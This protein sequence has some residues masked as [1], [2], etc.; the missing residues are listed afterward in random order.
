MRK[1]FKIFILAMFLMGCAIV[2]K[3]QPTKKGDDIVLSP[4]DESSPAKGQIKTFWKNI[5]KLEEMPKEKYNTMGS[6]VQA[7]QTAINNIKMKDKNYNT[8]SLEAELKKWQGQ[9]EKQQTVIVDQRHMLVETSGSLSRLFDRSN[10]KALKYRGNKPEEFEKCNKEIAE[11]KNDLAQFLAMEKDPRVMKDSAS[12]IKSITIRYFSNLDEEI[13]GYEENLKFYTLVNSLKG[14]IQEITIHET[15]IDAARQVYPNNTTFANGYKKMKELTSKISKI[16]LET[17]TKENKT[18]L[19][20]EARMPAAITSDPA[21]EQE[22]KIAFGKL[23][24]AGEKIIKVNLTKH[25][26]LVNRNEWTSIIENRTRK[27]AVAV[28]KADGSCQIYVMEIGQ[29]YLGGS[30]YGASETVRFSDYPI[31]CENVK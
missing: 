20:K 29:Q 25:D 11:Y 19:L 17:F 23:G 30:S 14:Y 16:N 1:E 10:D 22:F 3:A 13:K 15:Y 9:H 28:K 2:N 7:A 26:W 12:T 18:R 8:A 31:L 5:K 24:F 6:Y 27:A 4:A 21:I